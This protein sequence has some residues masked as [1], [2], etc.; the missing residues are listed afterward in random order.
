M[1]FLVPVTLQGLRVDCYHALT[2]GLELIFSDRFE[3]G[4]TTAWYK[5]VQ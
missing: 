2:Q 1:V 5:S 3:S 4:D